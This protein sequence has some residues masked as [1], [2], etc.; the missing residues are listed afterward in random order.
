M[1]IERRDWITR[2]MMRGEPDTL[3]V[4]GDNFAH[5]GFGGQAREMRGEPNAIGL[6][7]KRSPSKFMIDMDVHRVKRETHDDINTL[8]WH[9]EN[10]GIVVWPKDGIGTGLANLHWHAPVVERF[11]ADLLNELEGIAARSSNR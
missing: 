1:P 8:K 3:F 7:T 2:A 6:P 10:G 11:Y 5:V 9:L 4:F